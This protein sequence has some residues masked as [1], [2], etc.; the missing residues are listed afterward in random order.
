[1]TYR[2]RRVSGENVKRQLFAAADGRRF[3]VRVPEGGM[4]AVP[5]L[6]IVLHWPSTLKPAAR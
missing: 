1:L 3:L 5:P 6:E 2:G 4:A